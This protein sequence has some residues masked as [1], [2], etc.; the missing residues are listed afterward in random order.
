MLV[1]NRL[2]PLEQNALYTKDPNRYL[3]KKKARPLTI[4]IAS[5]CEANTGNPRIVFCSD[6]LVTDSNGLT[7]EQVTPK[8]VQLLPNCL[9]MN[10][11]DASHGD[12]I[13]RDV[14]AKMGTLP[15]DKVETIKT[16]EIVE[17]VKERLILQRSQAIET[18]I[19][20]PRG[21]D[22]K[23]FYSNLNN[24][25]DWFALLI[26][27]EVRN[28]Q[29]DVGFIVLG[30]DINQDLKRAV[31][32]LY[33]LR[34]NGEIQFE[35]QI[36]FSMVGIGSYQSL[37]EITKEP[38][39]PNTSLSDAIVRTF[40]AKKLSERMVG[41]GKESTDLGI[42]LVE[43]DV[44]QQKVISRNILTSDEFKNTLAEGFEKQKQDI[45]Q[46]T[47]EIEAKI[48]EVLEGKKAIGK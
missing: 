45:K 20:A 3:R 35:N 46:K 38:Y 44:S 22:R 23:F 2:N 47:I 37:P 8:I 13:L 18:D 10:A 30:F 12:I 11:G 31:P 28:Y 48:K 4:C 9:I 15:P 14:F 16:E 24:F 21:F 36:G 42:L 34:G 40:W 33:Q 32:N 25:K 5:I 17:M 19:F 6:R 41:V 1:K 7:F 26:D 27:M 39:N 43:F 29:F